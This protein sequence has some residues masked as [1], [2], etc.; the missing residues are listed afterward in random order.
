MPAPVLVAILN[1][2]N[3]QHEQEREERHGPPEHGQRRKLVQSC[4]GKEIQIRDTVELNEQ[5][6]R[7]ER[8]KRV[9]T[10][11]DL[12]PGELVLVVGAFGVVDVDQ[13]G[14]VLV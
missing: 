8:N 1:G 12:V 2:S 13:P 14:A 10:G 9:S 6:L 11:A 5:I 3:A 7:E 4:N